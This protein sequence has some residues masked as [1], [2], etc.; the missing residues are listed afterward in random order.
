MVDYQGKKV[1]IIGLGMIGLL[2]VDFFMVCGVI[3]CVMDICVVFLGLDKLFELVECYVGGFNDI[4]LLVVDLIVVSLGIV[5]VYFLFS[6]VVDVGVE[7]VGDIELF[8]C[9]V[10]VLIIVII[11]FNGKSIVIILVGEMVKVVGVNVGVGGNIG[12]LVL[13]LLDI[14]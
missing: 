8:C 5:L 7:I 14:D 3:L 2:C 11:G 4:W 9:E 13:M 10:Q 6:V 1:V 12:L